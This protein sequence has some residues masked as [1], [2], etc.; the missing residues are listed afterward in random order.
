MAIYHVADE[1]DTLDDYLRGY[2]RPLMLIRVRTN[3]ISL[4]F[5]SVPEVHIKAGAEWQTGQGH[6]ATNAIDAGMKAR[7]TPAEL[8]TMGPAFQQRYADYF[9]NAPDKPVMFGGVVST[10]LGDHACVSSDPVNDWLT[11]VRSAVPAGKYAMMG[12]YLTYPMSSGHVHIRD[13]SPFSAPDFDAGYLNHEADMA[14]QVWMFKKLREIMRRMPS[15][16]GEF[17]AIHPKYAEDSP[18]RCMPWA[19]STEPIVD[20]V[21]SDADTAAIE[22]WVRENVYVPR[23]WTDSY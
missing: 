14:P 10:F 9:E 2:A 17:A 23:R 5:F 21:Y 15:Y 1:A 11:S 22:Q 3:K 13:A 7:P 8:A 18:A 20:L 16:R 4:L 12:A 6:I 19:A